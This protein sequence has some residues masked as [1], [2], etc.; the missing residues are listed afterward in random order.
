[1]QPKKP[2]TSF[3][4]DWSPRARAPERSPGRPDVSL[5]VPPPPLPYSMFFVKPGAR[6]VALNVPPAP[7]PYSMFLIFPFCG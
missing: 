7:L 2:G 6:D 5:N 1:M 4:T 3:E